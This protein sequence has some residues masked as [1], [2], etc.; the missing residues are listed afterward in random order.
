MLNATLSG[1]SAALAG[2]RI[3][4]VELAQLFLD[5]I[6]RLNAELNAFITVDAT[7]RILQKMVSTTTSLQPN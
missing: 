4:S 1:L 5:R 7:R 6:A 3:S 2:K